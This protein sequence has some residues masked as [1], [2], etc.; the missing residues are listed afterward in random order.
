ME[1]GKKERLNVNR[2]ICI[3]GIN[4]YIK[5]YLKESVDIMSTGFFRNFVAILVYRENIFY[6]SPINLS[7]EKKVVI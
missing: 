7:E 1:C 3:E 4:R 2:I 6:F 5:Q